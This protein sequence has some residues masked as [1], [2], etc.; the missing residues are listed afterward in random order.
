M[1]FSSK[2]VLQ[3]PDVLSIQEDRGIRDEPAP[4]GNEATDVISLYT[5][6]GSRY[7]LDDQEFASVPPFAALVSV[8][9][10]DKDLQL[11]V[12]EGVWVSFHGKGLVRK[13]PDQPRNTIVTLMNGSHLSV[14]MI[15]QIS[16]ADAQKLEE[17]LRRIAAVKPDDPAGGMRRTGLLLQGVGDYCEM[18]ERTGAA[19]AHREALRLRE[20]VTETAYKPLALSEIYEKLKLSPSRSE[21]LFL[22]AFGA[23][24]VAYRM[25]LRLAKACELLIQS[26]MS[27]GQVARA[28][29]FADQ[30]YFW[31]VFKRR[32]GMAP[33]ALIFN[34]ARRRKSGGRKPA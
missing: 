22:K 14:P 11:G 7:I 4:W 34:T 9:V 1:D 31:R 18:S 6:G 17:S 23:T 33:S 3:L 27:V 24:P 20:L 29:G 25:Q 30:L 2:S 19:A 16:W 15:K 5:K 32:Y 8:G 21:Q 13:D 10:L 12:I 26:Q 28:V